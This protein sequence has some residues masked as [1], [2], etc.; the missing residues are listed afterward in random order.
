MIV[1]QTRGA[2]EETAHPVSAAAVRL[3]GE[4]RPVVVAAAGPPRSSPWRSAGKP[5]QLLVSLAVLGE[6][7]GRSA[8]EMA[9]DFAPEALALGAS[10][11][12]GEAGHTVAVQAL[13][14]RFG[15]E[16]AALLCGAEPPAHAP[17][18]A[19]L[20]AAGG[21]PGAVHNDCS[22]KHTFLRA[23][24]AAR[25]WPADYLPAEHPLQ[26]RILGAVAR[27]AGVAP[28]VAVDGCGV[29]TFVLPVEGM[30]TAW[31]R[32]AGAMAQGAPATPEDAALGA[33]GRAMAA[34]PWWV[35]GTGRIDAHFA[36]VAA[37]PLLTK[38]GAQ[39]ILNVALPA[40]GLGL[41]VKVHSGDDAAVA[42]A[43]EAWI[44]AVAPGALREDVPN[45]WAVAC[46]VVG[47]PIGA[48]LVTGLP[49][50]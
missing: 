31:A 5:W 8:A 2:F 13:L 45:P 41:A 3:A 37:E 17:T 25:G 32:L 11:H 22:G 35:S 26:Q 15:L 24:C 50:V 6:A 49:R 40:R 1:V 48:R 12:S 36:A 9:D 4:G 21:Q 16:E 42:V 28:G 46:N 43:A 38:I 34:H 39:G 23:A 29:P 44:R 7:S 18:H 19:A 30:A 14:A 10:S 47:R 20:L 27:A 33:I